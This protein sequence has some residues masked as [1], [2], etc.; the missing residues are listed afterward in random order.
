MIYWIWKKIPRYVCFDTLARLSL[1]VSK[2]SRVREISRQDVE[3]GKTRASKKAP[4]AAHAQSTAQEPA[5][6]SP[7]EPVEEAIFSAKPKDNADT[8]SL[9]YKSRRL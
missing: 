8:V 7:K 1:F 2:F 4:D 5:Q 3:A 6:L 9:R